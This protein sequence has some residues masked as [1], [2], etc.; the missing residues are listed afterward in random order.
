MSIGIDIGKFS[1]K[2]VELEKNN[3]LVVVKNIGKKNLF[4]DINKFDHD[5]ISKSQIKACIEDLCEQMKIKPKKIKNITSSLS[6]KLIDVRQISTL[7]MPDNELS[8]SLEL[9]AKKHVPLDGTDAIIDYHLLGSNNE[10]LDQI[11]LILSTTT[12]NIISEH[13]E[14]LKSCKIKPGI[15]DADP[16]AI[17]NI[18]QFSNDIS[19]QGSDVLVNIGNSTTTIVVWGKNSS[20]FTREIEIAGDRINKELIR[21]YSYDYLTAENKKIENGINSLDESKENDE[22]QDEIESSDSLPGGIMIE[23]KTIFNEMVDEIR[24]T[25]R[26]YMKNNNNSFFNTFYITGGSALLPGLNEFIASNLNVKVELLDPFKKINNS[27]KVN[28]PFE[29]SIALGLALRGME[30]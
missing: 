25:L 16:I 14:L 9:E 5:K 13:A 3:D 2:L 30:K 4:E 27:N 7:E 10:K 18:H 23:E 20:F 21:K 17:S 1:I 22:S 28:N 6:G 8:V 11:N 12:K 24:K 26:F 29:F 15:F 19:E